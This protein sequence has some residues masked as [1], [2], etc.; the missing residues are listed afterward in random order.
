MWMPV[1]IHYVLSANKSLLPDRIT[2][3]HFKPLLL[4]HRKNKVSVFF[5]FQQF[6]SHNSFWCGI[7]VPAL[8]F[9][10]MIV[11]DALQGIES[12]VKRTSPFSLPSAQVLYNTFFLGKEKDFFCHKT[13]SS[14]EEISVYFILLRFP[15]SLSSRTCSRNTFSDTTFFPLSGSLCL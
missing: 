7:Q 4:Q 9:S 8:L 5:S 11:R 1:S 10:F 6:F 12:L 3:I 15:L 14:C 2:A 13:P